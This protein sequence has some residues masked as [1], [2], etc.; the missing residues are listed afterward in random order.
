VTR[1]EVRR[2]FL[3]LLAGIAPE[4]ELSSLDSA[5]D[6]GAQLDIDSFGFLTLLARVHEELGVEVPDADARRLRTLDGAV[7]Y[8]G[9]RVGASG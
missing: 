9:D 7:S 5:R 8:L 2:R 4:A 1:A 3:A 6:L